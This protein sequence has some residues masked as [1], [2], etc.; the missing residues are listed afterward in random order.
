[1]ETPPKFKMGDQL[2][3]CGGWSGTVVQVIDGDDDWLY[4]LKAPGGAGSWIIRE[5]QLPSQIG[6]TPAKK[7]PIK[8]DD[9]LKRQLDQ[10]KRQEHDRRLTGYRT[11]DPNRPH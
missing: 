5:S 8:P 6:Q 9:P 1:M 2:T 4:E 7:A 3:D 11:M 10:V